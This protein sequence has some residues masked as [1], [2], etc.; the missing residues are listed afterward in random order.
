MNKKLKNQQTIIKPA[1]SFDITETIEAFIL[2][3]RSRHVG[4]GTISQF[5]HYKL[6]MFKRFCHRKRIMG[7]LD[8]SPELLRQFF[9]ELEETNH[10]EGGIHGFY[11]AL[12]TLFYWFENE[13]ELEDWKNPIRKIKMRSP[14]PLP[15]QPVSLDDIQR[16]ID[17]CDNS[18]LGKR[19]IAILYC[20]LDT[21]MRAAEF[22]SLDEHDLN[23]IHGS[24]LIRKGKGMRVRTVYLGKKSR[25]ALRAYLKLR[26]SDSTAL[27][28]TE[29]GG[30][31]TYWGLRQVIRRRAEKAKIKVPGLHDFRRAC[32]LQCLRNGMDIFS[33]QRLAGHSDIQILRTYLAQTSED[34]KIAHANHSPVDNAGI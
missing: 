24:L 29:F 16:M 7:L 32:F 1:L 22:V 18:L 23:I 27:W 4:K 8:V 6:Q 13:Y 5:Y 25:K 28:Q 17:I 26:K 3:R 15:L 31:I 30:R 21:G 12:K 19:D 34:L 20:L 2:D 14:K 9:M 10:T 11:R 33:L